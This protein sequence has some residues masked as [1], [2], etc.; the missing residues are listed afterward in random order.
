MS[1]YG[2]DKDGNLYLTY[3]VSVR[4]KEGTILLLG[5]GMDSVI[6]FYN[7]AEA[8]IPGALKTEIPVLMQ[9]SCDFA[10]GQPS[11]HA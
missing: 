2:V 11:Q 9:C 5:T 3:A 4:C 7:I 10:R 8:G 6:K 1:N